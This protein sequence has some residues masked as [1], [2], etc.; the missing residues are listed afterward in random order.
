MI[1]Y[2]FPIIALA[3]TTLNAGIVVN[4]IMPVP[5]GDEPEWVELYNNSDESVSFEKLY[6]QDATTANP[7]IAI[8][9]EPEQYAVVT[10]DT[11]ALRACRNIPD[12][13][14]LIYMKLPGLNNDGDMVTLRDADFVTL[15]SFAYKNKP[16]VRG[17]SFER[18]DS[19]LPAEGNYSVS[20]SVDSATCGYKNSLS[21]IQEES[22]VQDGNEFEIII[23][24]NPFRKGIGRNCTISFNGG[25]GEGLFSLS[26]IDMQ[27]RCVSEIETLKRTGKITQIDISDALHSLAVGAYFVKVDVKEIGTYNE[28]TETKLIVVGD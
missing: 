28:K 5:L 14:Q 7:F 9:L 27:G 16:T 26:I 17:Y 22:G 25:Y 10:K 8:T 19:K 13:V 15:D 1:K 11:A 21:K 20:Q 4:E 2:L 24:E 3:F 23:S 12:N 18:I 6:I